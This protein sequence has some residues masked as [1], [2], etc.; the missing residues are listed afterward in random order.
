MPTRKRAPSVREEKESLFHLQKQ[1]RIL[2][3]KTAGLELVLDVAMG[4]I[5]KATEWEAAI[6]LEEA[7]K[8]LNFKELKYQIADWKKEIE[9]I[10][11]TIRNTELAIVIKTQ[12]NLDSG[13]ENG[14]YPE[15]AEPPTQ[16][17]AKRT[18]KTDAL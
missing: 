1:S 11:T 5:E 3:F 9:E 8:F 18:K 16:Q 12:A 6:Q 17:P 14:A 10:E 7:L 13:T 15:E 2:K 4:E